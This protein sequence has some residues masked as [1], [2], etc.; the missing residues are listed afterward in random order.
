MLPA[1]HPEKTRQPTRTALQ[2]RRDYPGVALHDAVV[3][4]PIRAAVAILHAKRD[5][6]A[7]AHAQPEAAEAAVA[8][9]LGLP[10]LAGAG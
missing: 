2:L 7:V 3:R 6:V 1:R 5:A 9:A 4:E 8:G 10:K